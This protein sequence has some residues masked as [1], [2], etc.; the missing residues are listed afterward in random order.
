MLEAC[1]RL[2]PGQLPAIEETIRAEK[3]RAGRKTAWR[4]S[5]TLRE[6]PAFP[7]L[8]L[9]FD[10]PI[11]RSDPSGALGD[12][13]PEETASWQQ[14]A[15]TTPKDRKRERLDALETAFSACDMDGDQQVSI[16][17]LMDYTGKTKNTIRAWIDE[18]PDFERTETGVR[19]ISD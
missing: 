14:K 3:Q 5:G 15:K 13:H 18:H 17:E 4:L 11:H 6:F 2:L 8:N 1:R 19:K 12:I 16:A 7:D 10:Y 9:W